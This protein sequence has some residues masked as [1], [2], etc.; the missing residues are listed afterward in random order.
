M[1]KAGTILEGCI[2]SCIL[3]LFINVSRFFSTGIR[4]SLKLVL[5]GYRKGIILW[6][7]IL[8]WNNFCL[9]GKMSPTK[10]S[11]VVTWKVVLTLFCWYAFVF[12]GRILRNWRKDR[13]WLEDLKCWSAQKNLR[14]RLLA[15]A[16]KWQLQSYLCKCWKSTRVT[17]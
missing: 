11:R 10:A 7:V 8:S 2:G 6:N 12:S 15:V 13:E 4:V 17:V 9:S 16:K 5:I 1:E 3:W 14:C